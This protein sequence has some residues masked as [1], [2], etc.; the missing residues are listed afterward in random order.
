MA[1][2]RD[3]QC[4]LGGLV[5]GCTRRYFTNKMACSIADGGGYDYKFVEPPPDRLVCK[6]CYLPCRE[7]RLTSCGHIFCE[8]CLKQLQSSTTVSHACPVCRKEQFEVS[9]Q[10][11]ADRAIKALRVYCLNEDKGCGWIGELSILIEQKLGDKPIPECMRCDKCNEVIHYTSLTSHF[12]TD[13]P[14][15]CQY[16]NI[17]AER[18][19]IDNLHKEKCHKFPM[20]CPNNC[21]L[22]K[23]PQDGMDVHRMECPLEV[24]QCCHC[25]AEITRNNKEKHSNENKIEHLQLI[26]DEKFNSAFNELQRINVSIDGIKQGLIESISNDSTSSRGNNDLLTQPL[27]IRPKLIVAVLCVITAIL[28]M[29]FQSSFMQNKSEIQQQISVQLQDILDML[30]AT[31]NGLNEQNATCKNSLAQTKRHL[32]ELE[33]DIKTY[34][35]KLRRAESI[36]TK[37]ENNIEVLKDKLETAK[38]TNKSGHNELQTE[39]NKLNYLWS[40]A[41]NIYKS[42]KNLNDHMGSD[43]MWSEMIFLC[44]EMLVQGD[45]VA[46][47][48]VKMSNYTEKMKN[49]RQWYSSP[50]FTFEES[51]KVQIRV[52]PAVYGD[53]E[54]THDH[55]FVYLFLLKGP[56]QSGDWPIKGTFTME[57]LNQ[58]NDS[59]H[60]SSE[61]AFA[62][63]ATACNFKAVKLYSPTGHLTAHE[64]ICYQ[65]TSDYLQNDSL[66]F[67]ISYKDTRY[68]YYY[69]YHFTKSVLLPIAT[70]MI[71]VIVGTVVQKI[72]H[73]NL[74]AIISWGTFVIAGTILIG[75][76]LGGMLWVALTSLT[77]G[78]ILK[79]DKHIRKPPK[80]LSPSYTLGKYIGRKTSRMQEQE[81]NKNITVPPR[82]KAVQWCLVS[83]LSILANILLVDVLSMPWNIIWLVV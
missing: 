83:V 75:N 29:T 20:P 17:T 63:N 77:T 3:I 16:C 19:V 8:S 54:I 43:I 41:M 13:C 81:H 7:A 49:K 79:W 6:I 59:D 46:P 57:L 74:A 25:K 35:T 51:Y 80:T 12:T 37:L 45:Q 55:V 39:L 33:E 76:L 78:L 2:A 44:N 26:C 62:C 65:I 23:I 72:Q 34:K 1:G 32:N 69:Y 60:R 73:D 28:A 40:L 67:R 18:E 10:L 71:V 31:D 47:V 22:D 48:I 27:V 70:M 56:Q 68:N 42:C 24:I 58:L 61:M 50:F 53:G 38:P 64:T 66:Y 21:G 30:K 9:P 82:P 52:D 4:L 5:G 36:Q 15:C 14:C 11:E